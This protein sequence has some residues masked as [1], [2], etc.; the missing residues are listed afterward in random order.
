[1]CCFLLVE[2]N[3]HAMKK[4]ILLVF[5]SMVVSMQ[6]YS[7]DCN[8]EITETSGGGTY[9][10]NEDVTLSI[11]GDLDGATEW[12]WY[13]GECKDDDNKVGTGTFLTVKVTKTTSYYVVAT[14]DC[15]VDDQEC[16]EIIIVLD[17]E[18]PVVTTCPE[19]IIVD[20]EEGK[21]EAEVTYEEPTGTD[22][23]SEKL[24]VEL[25][26]GLGP[27]MIFP[28]GITTEKY[29]ITDENGNKSE[30]VFTVTVRILKSRLLHALKILK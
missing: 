22:N 1:M 4:S 13:I 11:T 19:D 7:Q 10:L 9:C 15:V 26:E 27:D 21:C 16:T 28:V 18:P 3:P 2:L 29:V 17:D 24:E 8:P 23:C 25:I 30:C 20:A 12:Q 6:A 14:G 5:V